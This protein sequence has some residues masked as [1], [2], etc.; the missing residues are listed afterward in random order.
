[1]TVLAT[2]IF[3]FGLIGG[4]GMYLS[5]LR[6]IKPITFTDDFYKDLKY[7]RC[8]LGTVLAI[9]EVSS[10]EVI[11]QGSISDAQRY[12]ERV[13]LGYEEWLKNQS[14]NMEEINGNVKF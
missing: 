6:D 5:G 10:T 4:V 2:V 12:F 14:M 13:Q 3:G 9:K 11:F 8:D 1:M 7:F